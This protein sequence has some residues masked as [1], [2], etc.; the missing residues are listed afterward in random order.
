MKH[1]TDDHTVDVLPPERALAGATPQRLADEIRD[2]L[3]RYD[4]SAREAAFLA[5]RIGLRLVY[6]R[7]TSAWGTLNAFIEEHLAGHSLR[8]LRNYMSVAERFAADA[9][10]LDKQARKLTDGAA[11]APILGQQLELF[12]DPAAR[13]EGAARKVVKWVGE[14]GLAQIY[15]DL[16]SAPGGA[17]YERKDAAGRLVKGKGARRVTPAQLAAQA[18][19]ECARLAAAM[20]AFWR[21]GHH[22]RVSADERAALRACAQE[23]AGK[24]G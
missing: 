5:I 19:H 23:L 18:T 13:L 10:L 12:T 21:A 16:R 4:R 14:R 8:T 11:L 1:P 2:D 20:A 6:V 24:L 17:T 3:A 9:G 22:A 15:S 7:D